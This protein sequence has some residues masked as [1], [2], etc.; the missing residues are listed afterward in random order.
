M[1]ETAQL[2]FNSM[3]GSIED[4]SAQIAEF[5]NKDTLSETDMIEFNMLAT[6][7]S[8]MMSLASGLVKTLTE[9]EQSVAQKM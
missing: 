2:A 7:Y 4:L 8:T 3:T 6:E 1:S 9:A 5:A